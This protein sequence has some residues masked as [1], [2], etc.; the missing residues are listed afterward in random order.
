[1]FYKANSNDVVWLNVRKSSVHSVSAYRFSNLICLKDKLWNADLSPEIADE[2]CDEIRKG[3]R[4]DILPELRGQMMAL[5]ESEP[6]D[7]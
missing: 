7:F 1:M 4:V 3:R 6:F 2:I 5:I